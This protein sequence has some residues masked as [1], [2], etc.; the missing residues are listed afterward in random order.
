MTTLKCDKVLKKTYA[1]PRVLKFKPTP[2]ASRFT[3]ANT[4]PFLQ[5]TVEGYTRFIQERKVTCK[6]LETKM[7]AIKLK[8]K[9]RYCKSIKERVINSSA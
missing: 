8:Y 2:S 4:I 3:Y 9:F 7:D 1:S 5:D 6:T